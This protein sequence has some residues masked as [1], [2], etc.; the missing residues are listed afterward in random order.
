MN[1]RSKLRTFW[2]L[3]R[4]RPLQLWELIQI[5]LEHRL[6]FSLYLLS[7][8]R[9]ATRI[10]ELR[11][12]NPV[13]PALKPYGNYYLD[14]K[15]LGA[16]PLVFSLGVGQ[17]TAFD[18]A[19]LARHDV[20]LH[21]FDPTPASKRHIAGLRLPPNA[22]FHDVAVTD[23]DGSVEMFIDDLETDFDRASS[24]SVH[25]R[26]VSSKAF[27]VQCRR[28]QTLMR[29]LGVQ[30]LDV[31]KL[32]IEGAAI[33]VLRDAFRSGIFPSQIACELER[34]ESHREVIHFLRDADALFAELRGYG[35]E[36][37]RTREKHK[38]CQIEILAVRMSAPPVEGR[39]AA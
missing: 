37:Y 33:V 28:M 35:Y 38:G 39:R 26:G 29:E 14:P 25:N 19:L 15:L 32:D 7:L 13:S 21:L 22:S 6:G 36:L 1:F 9:T 11:N 27:T 4:A 17:D 24:I 34:P 10:V 12:T 2:V 16:R 5:R 30:H 8:R 18:E 23:R 3:L 20:R 31:L